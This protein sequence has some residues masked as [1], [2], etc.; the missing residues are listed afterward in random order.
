MTEIALGIESIDAQHE[1]LIGL[2]QEFAQAV[3]HDASLE[4]VSE[5][6]QRALAAANEHFAHEEELIDRTNYPHAADHKFLHRHMRMELTTLA[7]GAMS[8]HLHDS[9]TLEQLQTML[10]VLHDHI[11]GPDTELAEHLKA[12]GVR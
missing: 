4:V 9:V 10:G 3:E 12:A 5:I 11:T 2:F 8:M 1:Q 6:V 7:G